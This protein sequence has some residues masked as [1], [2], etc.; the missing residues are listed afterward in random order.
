MEILKLKE[1]MEK[2]AYYTKQ[3]LNLYLNKEGESLNYWIKKMINKGLL[4]PIK[5]GFYISSFYLDKIKEKNEIEE[6]FEY[7]AGI[8]RYPSYISL[9]YALAKYGLRFIGDVG[10]VY[11][12]VEAVDKWRGYET[13]FEMKARP[14][15][16]MFFNN[17]RILT[18]QEAMTIS[19]ERGG[20]NPYFA[21]GLINRF[22]I[23][24]EA[25]VTTYA[26]A[27][28]AYIDR[29]PGASHSQEPWNQLKPSE[30]GK[31]LIIQI[32]HQFT[33]NGMEESLITSFIIQSGTNANGT[34]EFDDRDPT[35]QNMIV[36]DL[37]TGASLST[38]K[39][40]TEI[41]SFAVTSTGTIYKIKAVV[42]PKGEINI[43][44]DSA[45]EQ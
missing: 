29:G 37:V 12:V 44:I 33:L 45:V 25:L 13:V 1:M 39:P 28:R 9:E 5:K 2:L 7:L 38:S 40:G 43:Y 3:N 22:Q 27:V 11:Q 17:Y 4:I 35:K 15:E 8:I 31:A 26:Q 30:V 20:I 34:F 32:P 18:T 14:F 36:R 42:G 24:K 6:Y 19:S 10:T 21:A 41:S 16:T 23:P